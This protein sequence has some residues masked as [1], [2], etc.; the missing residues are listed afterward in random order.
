MTG[1]PTYSVTNTVSTQSLGELD[2]WLPPQGTPRVMVPVLIDLR[3]ARE[4]I[5]LPNVR[6]EVSARKA[7]L[8]LTVSGSEVARNSRYGD[9][10]NAPYIT[11]EIVESARKL[12]EQE[13]EASATGE[14]GIA[15]GLFGKLTAKI[16][17]RRLKKTAIETDNL[18][19]VAVNSYR[20]IY[21][22]RNC[23]DVIEPIPPR[24]LTGKYLGDSIGSRD[25]DMMEPLCFLTFH[26]NGEC[27]D[28]WLSVDRSDL[29]LALFDQ[30]TSLQIS[31]NREA[32]IGELIRRSV[33]SSSIST[34]GVSPHVGS[35]EI[36]LAHSRLEAVNVA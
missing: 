22:T 29:N 27:A 12:L 6:I 20:V 19:K 36:V 1:Q 2:L 26:S 32:V 14:F 30:R 35:Q 24:I 16:F 10:L 4:V 23:W 25:G 33:P 21:R 28:I 5:S 34:T 17:S 3:F 18:V 31:R 11:A 13:Q 8:R 9:L 7:R 15:Q